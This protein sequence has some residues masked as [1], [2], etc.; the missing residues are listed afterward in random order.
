MSDAVRDIIE[1]EDL[2]GIS[3]NILW[4]KE[5]IEEKLKPFRED[6]DDTVSGYEGKAKDT[7]STATILIEAMVKEVKEKAGAY[8]ETIKGHAERMSHTDEEASR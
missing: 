1:A 3:S 4:E 8:A 6:S 2:E 7:L 5:Y